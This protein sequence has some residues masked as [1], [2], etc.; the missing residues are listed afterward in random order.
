MFYRIHDV[1]GVVFRL[2]IITELE[3]FF[4][5]FN[6][7]AKHLQYD[8]MFQPVPRDVLV[9]AIKRIRGFVNMMSRLPGLSVRE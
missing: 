8:V 4:A 3:C 1:I 2:D 7:L 5:G 6:V 9:C